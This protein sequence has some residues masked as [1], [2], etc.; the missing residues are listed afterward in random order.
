MRTKSSILNIITAYLGQAVA[1]I[2]TLVARIFFVKI[3]GKEYLG[4][5]GLFNNI[6]TMLSL[7]ELGVGP[8][9][10]YSLYKPIANNNKEEIKSLMH[11]FKKLYTNIGMII[12]ILGTLLTPFLPYIIKEMPNIPNINLI[13]ILFVINSS[14]SYFFSYKRSLINSDKDRYVL[15]IIKYSVYLVL[16]IFQ[17]LFLVLTHNFIIFLILQIIS[18]L[19]ENILVSRKADKLYPYLKDKD[20]KELNKDTK[21]NIMKNTKAMIGHKLGS[22]VV[23]STDNILISSFIGIVEVGLYSNYYLITSALDSIANQIFNSITAS[24]GNLYATKDPKES[25]RVFKVVYFIDFVIYSIFTVALLSVIN[26]FI[27]LWLGKNMIFSL[28]IIS[29]IVLN[30][31][32]TGM[33]KAVLVFR[34]AMGLYYEDRYK[35]F[36]E[37]LINLV[38]SIIL[39][40]K[41]G[42]IGVFIGTTIS[43]IST[44]L[45]IEPYVL[46]KYGFKESSK[47]YFID[48]IKYFIITLLLT[49]FVYGINSLITVTGILGFIIKGL[50][51]VIITVCVIVLIFNDKEEYKYVVDLIKNSKRIVKEVK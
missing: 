6:L 36:F 14:V 12:L 25:Y 4:I 21:A 44:C 34:D 5:D 39:A 27:T 24:A 10:V 38:L 48:Y 29:V 20:V 22:V 47:T 9:I 1:I 13:Y 41:Y 3:L 49:I 32:L 42:V 23:R 30:F 28:P 8:A 7:V 26:P 2:I 15:P 33:R 11:L 51:S 46:Y 45:W 35:P 31:Y 17:I 43:T 50:I 16:N 18:T 37:S 19:T 40:I